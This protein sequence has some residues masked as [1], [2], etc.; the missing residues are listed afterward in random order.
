MDPQNKFPWDFPTFG[1]EF[2]INTK[3]I[4]LDLDGYLDFVGANINSEKAVGVSYG[5]DFVQN[6][7]LDP[8]PG[9][10]TTNFGH[11]LDVG[12]VDRDGYPDLVIGSPELD[13]AEDDIAVGRVDIHYG[14][15]FATVQSFEGA[16]AFAQFG[17]GIHVVDLDGNG[18]EEI[19]IGAG[20]EFGGRVHL[21]RHSTLRIIGTDQLPISTGGAIRYS[22]EVGELS[23]NRLYLVALGA[24]GSVPGIDLPL[25][26]GAVTLPLNPDALTTAA[27]AKVNTPVYEDFLG[28]TSSLGIGS[29]KLTVGPLPDPALAGTTVTAAAVVFDPA[30]QVEYA[31]D[32]AHFTIVP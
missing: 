3:L 24:S 26:S 14:P 21:L 29:A 11:G 27:L 25:P 23:A 15:D 13:N 28:V 20:I 2:W 6:L 9:D 1:P 5:P 7:V 10:F 8:P 18:F 32:A 31:T 12:D 30:G 17:V 4:D 16:H 22:L 19:L